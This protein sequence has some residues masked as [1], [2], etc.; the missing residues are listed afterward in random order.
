[1]QDN[2]TKHQGVGTDG[3]LRDQKQTILGTKI[4]KRGW[5]LMG[6]W[7]EEGQEKAAECRIQMK[8]VKGGLEIRLEGNPKRTPGAMWAA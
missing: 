6:E 8:S 2:I 4:I 7:G 3:V 5:G 1:M